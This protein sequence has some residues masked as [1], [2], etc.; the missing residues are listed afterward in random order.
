[1]KTMT[2]VSETLETTLASI[3]D[4]E[5][6]A[7]EFA[8]RAGF[9][10]QALEKIGIAVREIIANAVVHGNRHNRRK[11]IFLACS[12][13]TERLVIAISDQ[14]EGFDVNSLPD[15]VAAVALLRG[16]GRG[17]YLA[18]AFMDEFHVRSSSKSGT[19]VVL[20]KYLKINT[21]NSDAPHGQNRQTSTG[22]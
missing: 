16:S 20:V 2:T 21:R 8:R 7:I 19:T 18:R 6:S 5:T 10:D 15:P 4:G 14:G 1:M 13:T 3:D 11:K 22:L 17:I 12:S 9:R